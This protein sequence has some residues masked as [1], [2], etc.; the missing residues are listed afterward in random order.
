MQHLLTDLKHLLEGDLDS[1]FPE[2]QA[3]DEIAFMNDEAR[4]M[5]ENLSLIINDINKIM[6]SMANGDFTVN[7]EIE[8]KLRW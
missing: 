2:H 7:T 5:A 1:E 6:A 8:D 3:E 4:Q